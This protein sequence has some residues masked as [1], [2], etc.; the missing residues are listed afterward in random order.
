VADLSRNACCAIIAV[1]MKQSPG[2]TDITEFP[3]QSRVSSQRDLQDQ[4]HSARHDLMYIYVQ[5]TICTSLK[6]LD[7]TIE[8]I[9]LSVSRSDIYDSGK[10]C[11]PFF[12][13]PE[14]QP[15]VTP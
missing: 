4:Y 12:K 14:K 10:T 5:C 9:R 3:P 8:P 6:Q 7:S 13:A 2:S 15:S 1:I 11:G